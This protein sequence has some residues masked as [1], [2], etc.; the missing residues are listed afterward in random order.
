MNTEREND[1][2]RSRISNFTPNK[3]IGADNF[4]RRDNNPLSNLNTGI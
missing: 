2:F 4:F 1:D 3:S